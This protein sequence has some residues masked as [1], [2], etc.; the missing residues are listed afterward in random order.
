[1]NYQPLPFFNERRS[2]IDTIIFHCSAHKTNDM[3]EVLKQQ[4]LS[5][6]YII[7]TNGAITKLVEE[8]HRAWHG[9]EGSWREIK[10]DINSHSIG[11]EL[12]SLT[13]GQTPYTKKQIDSLI[14]LSKE[15]I[16]RWNIKPQNIIAHSDSAPTRKPDPGRSFPWKRLSEHGIGLW[17]NISNAKLAPTN[18]LKELLAGIG[19]NVDTLETFKASQYAFARHFMP[20][21]VQKID[22]INHLLQNTYPQDIDFSKN[23]RYISIAQAVY[24]SFN[25]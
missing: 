12:S 17:Y 6:H 15:L 25:S 22:N 13:L 24:V 7:D 23:K 5:C 3:I 9:G 19:Y 2:N 21:A 11:I 16:N 20:R 10:E 14:L 4:Q 18:N 1:M 8:Q